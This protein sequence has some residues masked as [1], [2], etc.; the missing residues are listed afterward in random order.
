MKIGDKRSEK[1]KKREDRNDGNNKMRSDSQ[2]PDPL[3]TGAKAT[4]SREK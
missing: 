3:G 1:T 4:T 2:R